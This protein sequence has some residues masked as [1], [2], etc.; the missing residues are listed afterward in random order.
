MGTLTPGATYIYERSEG[1]IY[2]RRFG[3]TERIVV[4]YESAKDY[5]RTAANSRIMSELNEVVR[6]CETDPAMKELLDRL[7]VLY[8]LKK[9]HE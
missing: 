9:T 4:G 7:F 3:E 2:A 1:I 8:N 5:D 6:M